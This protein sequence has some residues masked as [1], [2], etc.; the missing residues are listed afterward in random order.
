MC[1]AVM[2]PRNLNRNKRRAFI[3]EN[4]TPFK[5]EAQKTMLTHTLSVE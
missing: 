5:V 2:S 3:K 1:P 4:P